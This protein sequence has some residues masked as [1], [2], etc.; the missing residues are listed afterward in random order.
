M[1]NN[2]KNVLEDGGN[3]PLHQAGLEA[4]A[5]VEKRKRGRPPGSA[6]KN[7]RD[8][9]NEAE[10][11]QQQRI[12]AE[13]EKLFASEVWEMVVRAPADVMLATTGNAARWNLGDKEVKSL[14]VTASNAARYTLAVDPRLLAVIMFAITGT[15]IYLPRAI[16]QIAESRG[17]KKKENNSEK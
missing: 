13:L 15:S 9:L 5:A 6:G 7:K 3:G 1:D 10:A 8:V 14:A 12:S 2:E 17:K 16:A 11:A 4:A